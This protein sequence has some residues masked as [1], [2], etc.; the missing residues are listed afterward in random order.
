MALA[1]VSQFASTLNVTPTDDQKI[2]ISSALEQSTSLIEGY[3]DRIFGQATYSQWYSIDYIPEEPTI[4]WTEQY[5]ITKIAMVGIPQNVA[6]LQNSNVSATM[7][8]AGYDSNV[9]SL[10][11]F[12]TLGDENEVDLQTSTHKTLTT[13]KHAIETN[14]GWSLNFDTKYANYPSKMIQPFQASITESAID[15]SLPVPTN[16]TAKIYDEMGVQ[17]NSTAKDIYIKYTAGYVLPVDATGN[18]SLAVVGTVTGELCFVCCQ[19]ANDIMAFGKS[20]T[21]DT[22][23]NSNQIVSETLGDYSYS[24]L[25]TAVVEQIV[26]KYQPILDKYSHK[27]L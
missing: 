4:I 3:C 13:L 9:V 5:P 21:S 18:A 22:G 11:W 8:S 1:T 26:N 25:P 14:T 7:S 15:I 19:I 6:S 27:F 2:I 16:S 23:V 24:K 12:D 20:A 17:L 10:M